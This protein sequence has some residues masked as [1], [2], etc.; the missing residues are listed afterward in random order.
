MTVWFAGQYTDEAPSFIKPDRGRGKESLYAL[1]QFR[2]ARRGVVEFMQ[3]ARKAAEVVNRARSL[4]GCYQRTT[5]SL[6]G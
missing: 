2:I 6:G 3:L 4:Q 5:H 1:R